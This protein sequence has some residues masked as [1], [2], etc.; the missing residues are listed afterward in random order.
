MKISELV[1][2]LET[3]EK[4]PVKRRG[5]NGRSRKAK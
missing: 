5:V 2:M 3:E 1:E 4:K